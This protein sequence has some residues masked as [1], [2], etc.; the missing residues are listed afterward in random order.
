VGKICTA[1]GEKYPSFLPFLKRCPRDLPGSQLIFFIFNR[2]HQA[3]FLSIFVLISAWNL[4][5]TSFPKLKKDLCH[6]DS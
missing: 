4:H 2:L 1:G 6:E 5:L 3:K